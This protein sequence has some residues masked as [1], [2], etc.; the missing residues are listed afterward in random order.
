[1]PF[2]SALY[3]VSS[4]FPK[5][6]GDTFLEPPSAVIAPS[7]VKHM[8]SPNVQVRHRELDPAQ[9]DTGKDTQKL[10]EEDC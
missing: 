5:P 10:V 3:E 2:F 6:K 8:S 4:D 9:Q 7:S 1:M